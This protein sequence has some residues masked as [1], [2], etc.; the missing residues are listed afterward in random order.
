MVLKK[1]SA[2]DQTDLKE[3]PLASGLSFFPA[4]S[5]NVADLISPQKDFELNVSVGVGAGGG[6]TDNSDHQDGQ[7]LF[8]LWYYNFNNNRFLF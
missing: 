7:E 6:S 1:S 5:V 2:H 3:A 4:V 8:P